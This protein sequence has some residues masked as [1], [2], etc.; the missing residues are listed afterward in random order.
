MGNLQKVT[1]ISV[2]VSLTSSFPFSRMFY[3]S[4]PFLSFHP[5]CLPFRHP[6]SHRHSIHSPI[7]VDVGGCHCVAEVGPHLEH[8]T[9]K[10]QLACNHT[11]VHRSLSLLSFSFSMSFFSFVPSATTPRSFPLQSLNPTIPRGLL[12]SL[13]MKLSVRASVSSRRGRGSGDWGL[14]LL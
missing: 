10:T 4:L 3:I 13:F 1:L 12:Y 11:T 9:N 8:I 5:F 7:V 14:K 6:P 2:S